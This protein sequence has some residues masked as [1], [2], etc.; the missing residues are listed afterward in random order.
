MTT[1]EAEQ[2]SEAEAGLQHGGVD[3]GGTLAGAGG[4]GV[5]IVRFAGWIE[6]HLEDFG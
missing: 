6:R 2:G 1:L 3:F 5:G 4:F